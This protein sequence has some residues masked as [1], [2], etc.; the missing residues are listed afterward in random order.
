MSNAKTMGA[1]FNKLLNYINTTLV[2]DSNY[3]IALL[4][5]QNYKKLKDV[6]IEEMAQMCYTSKASV[7]R[8]IRFIGFENFKEFKQSL[9]QDFTMSNDYSRQFYQQL[10][11]DETSAIQAYTEML[12]ADIR[13]TRTPENMDTICHVTEKIYESDRISFF[14]HHFL[15]DAGRYY[16][17]KMM[18]MGKYVEMFMSYEDQLQS[19]RS[20]NQ[21]SVAVICTV[22]GT[23]M[24]RYSEIWNAIIQS[25][26]KIIVITQNQSNAELNKADYVIQCGTSNK[27]D[28]GKYCALLIVE[29]LIMFYLK[30]YNMEE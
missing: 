8:F 18:T 30:T 6:S 17:S 24:S 21:D 15:W 23:Y 2:K 25:G 5:I 3:E 29:Y 22:G 28:I 27:E 11:T 12:I 10:C 7:S 14:A 9:N 16:Q 19:A 20:L 13:S 4:L 1:L 26:C